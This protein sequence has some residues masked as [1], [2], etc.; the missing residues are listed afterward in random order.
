MIGN[1]YTHNKGVPQCLRQIL[2]VNKGRN[3]HPA[4]LTHTQSTT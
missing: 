3:C 2:T 4:Y 1:I